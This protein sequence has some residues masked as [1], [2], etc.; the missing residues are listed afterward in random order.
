M[1]MPQ[2]SFSLINLIFLKIINLKKLKI[3]SN[4]LLNGLKKNLIVFLFI[5]YRNKLKLIILKK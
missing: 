2:I 3:I 4:L 1:K 5:I